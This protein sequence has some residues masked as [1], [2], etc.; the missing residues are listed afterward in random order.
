MN[1]FE[2][3]TPDFPIGLA[4]DWHCDL[5]WAMHAID[6]FEKRGIKYILHLGD[7]GIW[8]GPDGQKYTRR[9]NKILESKNMKIFV[10][11]GNHENYNL[12]E[13]HYLKNS[14]GLLVKNT[15]PN[16]HLFTRGF[17]WEWHGHRFMSFGGANSID[18]MFR[19]KDKSWWEQEQITDSQIES[20][21]S[22]LL[23]DVL[24]THDSP[25]G[26]DMKF[27]HRSTS[28]WPKE[29]LAYSNESRHQLKKVT[30]IVQP[31]LLFHGHY[32]MYLDETTLLRAPENA[33]YIVRSVCLDKEYTNQNMGLLNPETLE[34]R[35]LTSWN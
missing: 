21:D 20:L 33:E 16:I 34:F 23:V 8:G 7:F 25:F 3:K 27:N 5:A 14:E 19:K 24:F 6:E 15:E 1:I 22:N 32:H 12:I 30:D 26:V 28:E 2:N 29:A 9:I 13:K 4:G 31:N 11:L 10:T 17:N 35:L 18:K